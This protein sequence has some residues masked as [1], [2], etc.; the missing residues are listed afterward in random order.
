MG[1][2]ACQVI[3][4]PV[5]KIASY[6]VIMKRPISFSTIDIPAIQPT[7]LMDLNGLCNRS[8]ISSSS[9]SL[10]SNASKCRDSFIT[11]TSIISRQPTEDLRILRDNLTFSTKE[12]RDSKSLSTITDTYYETST[13]QRPPS[14]TNLTRASK[15]KLSQ[16]HALSTI[17][18]TFYE[19]QTFT[20]RSPK[21][22]IVDINKR[23]TAASNSKQQVRV[24][25]AGQEKVTSEASVSTNKSSVASNDGGG[26]M[27]FFKGMLKSS[28]A[29]SAILPPNNQ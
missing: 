4:K 6:G 13:Q 27:G 9:I 24:E 2:L 29:P 5:V 28:S 22:Q 12:K 14:T 16:P 21:T 17:T 23:K 3:S 19:T 15:H 8:S 10:P 1:P 25:Q 20:S 26:V 18:D 7:V 11:V